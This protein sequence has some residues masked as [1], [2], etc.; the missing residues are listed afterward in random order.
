M[1]EANGQQGGDDVRRSGPPFGR[2]LWLAIGA[3]V[4]VAALFG[5]YRWYVS[6][7]ASTT[8]PEAPPPPAVAVARPLV[9][10]LVEWDEFTG[11]FEAVEAVEVRARVAGYL[12]K[13]HFKDGQL[14]QAGQLLFTIDQ[15]PF[16]RAL[17]Q[18]QA[19]VE[20]AQAGLQQAVLNLERAE[21]LRTSGSPAFQ[22]AAYE[23][24]IQAKL[25][26]QAQLDRASALRAEAQ[27]DLDFTEVS[28]PTSGRISDRRVD[29]GNLVSDATLLTTIVSQDPIYFVFDMSEQD[30][31]AYERAVRRGEL[32][33]TGDAETIVH[34]NLADETDWHRT[35][36]MN[37]VDNVVDRSTGTVRAR[38]VLDNKDLLITPGQ[39]GQIRIPGSPLYPAIL[40]PDDAVVTDQNQKLVMLVDG[41]GTVQPR[42]IRPGP[43]VLGLRIVRQGLEGDE[44]VIVK[45]LIRARPGMHV[46]AEETTLALPAD[47]QPNAE[48]RP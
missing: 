40:I 2:A 28:A 13:V 12:E 15:R 7:A 16:Q 30:Y 10:E 47:E 20:S 43:H 21:A 38:A 22:R 44:R 39:F 14:V 8:S 42:V 41:Q 11:R 37:F 46:S 32:P 35:G 6:P 3:V 29:V 17:E 34:I 19:A 45:G 26:A 9:H 31:L 36:R 24:A 1:A 4:I 18:A 23:D 5:G 25:G 27:L 48:E 33:S